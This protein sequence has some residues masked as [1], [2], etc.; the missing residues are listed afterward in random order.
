MADVSA[1][2]L[3]RR[4]T[5]GDS[6]RGQLLLVGALALATL[7]VALALF[8]NGVI[9]AGTLATDDAGAD[10]DGALAFRN[11]ADGVV[12]SVNAEYHADYPSLADDLDRTVRE[13][14]AGVG[15]HHAARGVATNASLIAYDGGTRIAQNDAARSFTD[16]NGASNWRVVS[17]APGVRSYAL[18]VDRSSLDGPGDSPLTVA[19]ENGTA[20]WNVSVARTAAGVSVAVERTSAADPGACVAP[21]PEGSTAT[22]DLTGGTLAGRRCAP[23][24]AVDW[25]GDSTVAYRNATSAAGTYSFVFN[26]SVGAATGGTVDES[27]YGDG[28]AGGSPH[29]AP[30]VY[31]AELDLGYRSPSLTYE[32]RV[33]VAPGEPDA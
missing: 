31:A 26:E 33:R 1:G 15:R 20:A 11:A 7:F 10:A 29:F 22:V 25:S 13:W 28:A 9:Y 2:R 30:A 21:V 18:T 3:D 19:V 8:L 17:G 24:A 27:R 16:A 4:P 6:D 5:R 14:S 32:T 12:R 23:L